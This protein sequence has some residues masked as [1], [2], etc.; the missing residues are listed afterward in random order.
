MHPKPVQQPTQLNP[1]AEEFTPSLLPPVWEC[2]CGAVIYG[3][4]DNCGMCGID[5]DDETAI[6]VQMNVICGGEFD[7]DEEFCE[8]DGEEF[9]ED[10]GEEF[11]EEFE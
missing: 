2:A 5:E 3:N 10:N 7:D 11:D 4:Y 1:N 6:E 8:D 9:C